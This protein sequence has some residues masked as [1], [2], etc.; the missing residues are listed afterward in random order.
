MAIVEID[1]TLA[2]E[3]NTTLG[4]TATYAAGVSL[5]GDATILIDPDLTDTEAL[6]MDG[7][8]SFDVSGALLA[9][10]GMTPVGGSTLSFDTAGITINNFSRGPQVPVETSSVVIPRVRVTPARPRAPGNKIN[11]TISNKRRKGE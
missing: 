11:T 9:A 8:S 7:E 1:A 10:L 6:M 4:A 3:S 5:I 2:G